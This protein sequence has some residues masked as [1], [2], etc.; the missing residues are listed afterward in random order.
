MPNNVELL[1]NSCYTR[2]N[3]QNILLTTFHRFYA[4]FTFVKIPITLLLLAFASPKLWT[5]KAQIFR[6]SAVFKKQIPTMHIS[7]RDLIFPAPSGKWKTRLIMLI[8]LLSQIYCICEV[9]WENPLEV[10][11]NVFEQN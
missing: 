3:F 8:Y 2:T 10:W 5:L 1:C 7:K 9:V 11:K 4:W 6:E